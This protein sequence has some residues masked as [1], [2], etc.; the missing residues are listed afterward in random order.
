MSRVSNAILG[1]Q[2]ESLLYH[3]SAEPEDDGDFIRTRDL[4][5]DGNGN[6]NR[7]GILY[8]LALTCSL[9]G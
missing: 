1:E 2:T 8:L 3:P 5:V 6:E 9:G 4:F 7:V